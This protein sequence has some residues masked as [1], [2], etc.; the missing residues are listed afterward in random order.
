[1][2]IKTETRT[3][4]IM[5]KHWCGGQNGGYNPDCFDDLEPNFPESHPKRLDG[6]YTILASDEDVNE[7]I[8]WWTDEVDNANHGEYDGDGLCCLTDEERERGDEW[9]LFVTERV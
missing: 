2:T 1:M 6:D 7:L 9:A 5:L 3:V 8:D 4:E